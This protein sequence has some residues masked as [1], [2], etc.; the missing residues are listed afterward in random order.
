[1]L[2]HRRDLANTH[3]RIGEALL[4]AGRPADA[5]ASLAAGLRLREWLVEPDPQDIFARR[6]PALSHPHPPH[7]PRRP[8]H[9]PPHRPP[10]ARRQHLAAARD[11]YQRALAV[12]A[13]LRRRGALKPADQSEVDR[14]TQKLRTLPSVPQT[15]ATPP[16]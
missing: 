8:P 3:N 6:A 13:D 14:V 12:W 5:L 4:V 7:L 10:A 9:A 15:R 11:L 1:N 16:A 2:Q